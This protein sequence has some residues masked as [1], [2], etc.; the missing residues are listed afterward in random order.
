MELPKYKKK[1]IRK[2]KLCQDPSCG[3]EYFGNPVSKYCEMHRDVKFR[4]RKRKFYK[5]LE[6]ENMVFRHGFRDT[7]E[8]EFACRLQGCSGKYI[9]RVI[10]RLY[11]YPKYCDEHRNEYKREIFTKINKML[12]GIKIPEYVDNSA[13]IQ[14]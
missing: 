8:M 10:P 6:E 4:K 5:P 14:S 3:K 7:T 11:V 1:I 12:T 2:L 13:N 9:V